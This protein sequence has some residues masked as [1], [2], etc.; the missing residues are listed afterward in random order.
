MAVGVVFGDQFVALPEK[1]RGF[2]IHDFADAPAKGVVAIAGGLAIGFFDG[3]Q[4]MLAVVA[5]F[6]DHCLA[7]S[8]A[9]ADQVAEGVV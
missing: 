3:D 1:L 7:F 5:V 9:F 2:V 8:P 4:S 6:G